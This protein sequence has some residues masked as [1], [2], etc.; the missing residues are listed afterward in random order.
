MPA[1]RWASLAVL[2][3]AAVF[4]ARAATA[5]PWCSDG[6]VV[7][8][9]PQMRNAKVASPLHIHAQIT[10][11]DDVQINWQLKDSTGASLAAGSTWDDP[12]ALKR[13]SATAEAFDFVVYLIDPARSDH[14]ALTLTPTRTDVSSEKMN[15]PPLVIPVRL[16]TATSELTILVPEDR[17][18][19]DA[20]VEAYADEPVAKD[21]APKTPLVPQKV[22][23]MK[24]DESSRMA[25]TA[26]AVLRSMPAQ[27]GPWHVESLR[28]DKGTAHLKLSSDAWAGVSYYWLAV[29]H[30]LEKTLEQFPAIQRVEFQ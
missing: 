23:V 5:A 9:S 10:A 26:Q 3:M 29:G 7:C 2:M 25:A 11:N 13:I 20:D 4:H 22:T 1:L 28:L 27:G 14:G 12:E 8:V 18:G 24:V 17:A 6:K 19:Y 15:L 30:L 21:F 16:E